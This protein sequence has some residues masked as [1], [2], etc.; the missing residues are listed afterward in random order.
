[1]QICPRCQKSRRF[2][3]SVARDLKNKRKQW[4]IRSCMSCDFHIDIQ[5]HRPDKTNDEDE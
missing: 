5:E 4:L 2:R 3:E 1:M